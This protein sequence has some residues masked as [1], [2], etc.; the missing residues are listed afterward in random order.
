MI[1]KFHVYYLILPRFRDLVKSLVAGLTSCCRCTRSL[2]SC[3]GDCPGRLTRGSGSRE[4][5]INIQENQQAENRADR[6]ERD[7]ERGNR[8]EMVVAQEVLQWSGEGVSVSGRLVLGEQGA[9]ERTDRRNLLHIL[10]GHIRQTVAVC[11]QTVGWYKTL[12]ESPFL[13]LC[14]STLRAT[15]FDPLI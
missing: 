6:T 2:T 4:N 13:T 5:L 14:Q 7:E 1:Y 8:V 12:R 9:G 3:C 15:P 11:R 10:R